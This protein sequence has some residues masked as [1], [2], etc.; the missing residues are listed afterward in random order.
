MYVLYNNNANRAMYGAL[1]AVLS[2]IHHPVS[3]LRFSPVRCGIIL[4]A[5]MT[6]TL[7]VTVTVTTAIV[8]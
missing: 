3:R 6:D 4:H 2:I 7:V 8:T 1:Q 5:S